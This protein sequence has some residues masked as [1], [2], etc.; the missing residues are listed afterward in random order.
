MNKDVYIMK[1]QRSEKFYEVVGTLKFS[2]R[3]KSTIFEGKPF[4]V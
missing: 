4:H 1:K 2:N 3:V